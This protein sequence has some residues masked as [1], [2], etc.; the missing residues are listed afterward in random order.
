MKGARSL[1]VLAVCVAASVPVTVLAADSVT[2][3]SAGF[4]SYFGHAH[5]DLFS[6][7]ADREAV[8]TSSRARRDLLSDCTPP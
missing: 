8:G 2:D 1:A 7:Q 3:S 4:G 5:A 6:Q